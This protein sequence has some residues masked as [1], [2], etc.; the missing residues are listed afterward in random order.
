[1][2][3]ATIYDARNNF[4]SLVKT[5]EG[6][7]VVQ[8]TRHD[9]P[10]AVLIGWDEY[11]KTRPKNDFFEWLEKFKKE[12]ADI[13]TDDNPLNLQPKEYLDEAYEKKIAA[14]WSDV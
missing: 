12:N 7:E 3:S 2:C 1:M 5:A 11:E 8:L 14:L 10:V 6:G 4:S 9:K 13:L